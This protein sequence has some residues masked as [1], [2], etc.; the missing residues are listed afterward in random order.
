MS[1]RAFRGPLRARYRGSHGRRDGRHLLALRGRH[2]DHRVPDRLH[3]LAAR[4]GRVINPLRSEQEAFRFTLIVAVLVAPIVLAAIMFGLGRRAWRGRAA[5]AR[6]GVRLPDAARGPQAAERVDLRRRARRRHG[7]D[8][9]RRQRDAHRRGAAARDR[10][11]LPGQGR[12]RSGSSARRSTRGSSTGPPTRTAPARRPTSG[13]TRSS[14]TLERDGLR[15]PRATSATATPSR[16]WRTSCGKFPADEVII[17]THPPGP[18]QLARA[19]RDRARAGALRDPGHPRGRGPRAR[20]R[21]RELLDGQRALHPG[22]L[23]AGNAAV[24]GVAAGLEV[25]RDPRGL[26]ARD[27]LALRGRPGARCRAG[28]RSR[29]STRGSPCRPSPSTLLNL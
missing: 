21:R 12:P 18:L 4:R 20:G 19:R 8:P 26:A 2:V 13:W 22:L 17:S 25:D 7:A 15:R 6:A 14:P 10:A 1:I 29:S 3:P 27:L 28:P 16:P 11:A 23:V 5:C 24:E 9:G